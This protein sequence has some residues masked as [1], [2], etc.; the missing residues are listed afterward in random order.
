MR[1]WWDERVYVDA[2]RECAGV[3]SAVGRKRIRQQRNVNRKTHTTPQAAGLE[4]NAIE[5]QHERV[6]DSTAEQQA[7]VDGVTAAWLRDCVRELCVA[8]AFS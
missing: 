8:S 4:R 5:R 7:V 6:R 3:C 2:K 1:A